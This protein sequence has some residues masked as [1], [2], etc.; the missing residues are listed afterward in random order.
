MG[1]GL[2]PDGT[3]MHGISMVTDLDLSNSPLF[4][5]P[6]GRKSNQLPADVAAYEGH[7][8]INKLNKAQNFIGRSTSS[9]LPFLSK[10]S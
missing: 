3:V 7:A 9:D 6:F 1:R 4:G 5:W 2:Q 10:S 8:D